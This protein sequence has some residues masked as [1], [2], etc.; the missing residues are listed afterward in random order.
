MYIQSTL[1]NT[2]ET[3]RVRYFL[4]LLIDKQKPLM[5]VGPAGSGKSVLIGDKLFSLS[6][7][8]TVTNISFNFYTTSGKFTTRDESPDF[9]NFWKIL[10]L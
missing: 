8:Y 4:D 9:V 1:V 3:T 10:Q 2:A 6:A 5:L 7:N